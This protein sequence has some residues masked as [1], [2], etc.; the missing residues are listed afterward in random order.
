MADFLIS[1]LRVDSLIPGKDWRYLRTVP[2]SQITEYLGSDGFSSN[3]PLRKRVTNGCSPK[4][5]LCPSMMTD[6][7]A[8][9]AVLMAL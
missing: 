8:E 4:V 3:I 5:V 9:R 1:Y 2:T 7:N 6:D